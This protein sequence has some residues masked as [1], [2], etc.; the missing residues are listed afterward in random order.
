VGLTANWSQE[1]RE[2]WGIKGL[3]SADSLS[4]AV[5]WTTRCSKT[6]SG[7]HSGTPKELYTSSV[8]RYFY[9]RM[10]EQGLR[11]GVLSDKYGLHFD[12]EKLPNYDIH[13]SDLS[14]YDKE[15]L[16][17]LIRDKALAQGFT[18]IIFYS[19]SP[20]MSVPYFEMLHH[21]GLDVFYTTRVDFSRGPVQLHNPHPTHRQALAAQL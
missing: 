8:N 9:R 6:K 14:Q 13:P 21:S 17:Q 3:E 10:E 18:Q 1:I 2:R 12:G 16:G 19:S 11:Y 5:L 15:W 7:V 4:E 20:L